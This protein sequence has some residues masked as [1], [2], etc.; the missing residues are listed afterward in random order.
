MSDAQHFASSPPPPQEQQEQQQKARPKSPPLAFEPTSND[1]LAPLISPPPQSTTFASPPT[2]AMGRNSPPL[3]EGQDLQVIVDQQYNAITRLHEA[4]AAERQC[5]ALEKERL[6]QRIG[7][8]ERLLRQR[9]NGHRY[10][11]PLQLQRGK[12]AKTDA[13]S[14][15]KSPAASP[16]NGRSIASPQAR[17]VNA[18]AP[19]LPS[20]AEDENIQPYSLPNNPEAQP[21]PQTIDLPSMTSITEEPP[22]AEG[23]RSSVSFNTTT[24]GTNGD[25]LVDEVP[26]SPP[27]SARAL[28]PPPA[29]NTELAGHTPLKTSRPPTPPPAK[30]LLADET[31]DDTPTRTNTHINTL[32]TQQSLEGSS[33]DPALTGPLNLPSLPCAPDQTNFTM[34]ALSA[35]LQSISASP[36]THLPHVFTSPSPG[37]AP[38]PKSQNSSNNHKTLSDSVDRPSQAM[39]PLSLTGSTDAMAAM[40]AVADGEDARLDLDGGENGGIRLKKKV[41]TNFGAPFGS[42][43]GFGGRKFS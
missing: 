11:E 37:L 41:S 14:P 15:A 29:A 13:A 12:P 18:G 40:D 16:T 34:E 30:H 43:G 32:L 33:D 27:T 7:G 1:A 4:F 35:R 3:G 22:A 21:A 19:R 36:E 10:T 17:A 24:D 39:S 8:L 26:I 28:S 20:I 38:L 5:W 42:L 31:L 2:S 6:H 25:V 9:D 23:R